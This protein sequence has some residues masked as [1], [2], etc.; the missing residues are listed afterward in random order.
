[1]D[2]YLWFIAALVLSIIEIITPGFVILWFGVSAAIVGIA[3]LLGL[4]NTFWQI[5]I[6]I[7]LSLI[8]VI[9]SRTFFK[10]IFIK[11]PG[12]NYKS[13]ID[14]LIGQKGIVTED[15]DNVKGNGRIKVQGQD[16]SARSDDDSIIPAG[17]PV[18]I[19]RYEGV[20]LFVKIIN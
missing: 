18:E 7:V 4:H 11:S 20:K 9:L 5:I 10:T 13:N 3:D 6:W 2:Y 12:E 16:W 14:V 8:F 17:S 1:M 15:I 19:V